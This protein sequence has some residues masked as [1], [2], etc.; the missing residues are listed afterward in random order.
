MFLWVIFIP[1]DVVI[2]CY[3]MTFILIENNVNM[4]G[5]YVT[6][7]YMVIANYNF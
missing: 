3:R 5:K 2:F 6:L 1:K 7:F 4:S